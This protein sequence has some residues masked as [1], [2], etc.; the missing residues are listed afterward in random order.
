[1]IFKNH[2]FSQLKPLLHPLDSLYTYG[3]K[4]ILNKTLRAQVPK[5][6]FF[7]VSFKSPFP[8]SD[9]RSTFPAHLCASIQNTLTLEHTR[10]VIM[11]HVKH[12]DQK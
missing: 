10:Q 2:H 12:Q 3:P 9:S 11:F 1:M 4:S 7:L 6:P 8:Y 5:N